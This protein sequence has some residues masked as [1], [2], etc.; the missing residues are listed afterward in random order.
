[1]ETI[2][3][4]RLLSVAETA[5]RLNISVHTLRKHVE[6]RRLPFV[7]IGGRVLFSPADLAAFVDAHRVPVRARGPS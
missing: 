1:M 4:E 7:R 2:L 5:E 3:D 6:H